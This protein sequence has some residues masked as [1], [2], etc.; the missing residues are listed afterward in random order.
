MIAAGPKKLPIVIMIDFHSDRMSKECFGALLS[1]LKSR[2]YNTLCV[3]TIP[4]DQVEILHHYTLS[5]SISE[6]ILQEVYE[7]L[8]SHQVPIVNKEQLP[9]I[10]Y[11]ELAALLFS[12]GISNYQEVADQIYCMPSARKT[13]KAITEA[14]NS[15]FMLRGVDINDREKNKTPL[16]IGIR[17]HNE[18]ILE[19]AQIRGTVIAANVIKLRK[20]K[21]HNH[22]E[23]GIIVH[24]GAGNY[25]KM[26]SYFREQGILADCLFLYPHQSTYKGQSYEVAEQQLVKVDFTGVNGHIFVVDNEI[27]VSFFA[28]GALAQLERLGVKKIASPSAMTKSFDKTKDQQPPQKPDNSGGMDFMKGAFSKPGGLFL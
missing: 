6:R 1:E 18:M 19:T 17:K 22:D 20:E 28:Q 8:R 15:G 26:V 25:P 2:G 11:V 4:V 21:E 23:G 12:S 13:L 14:V 5:M 24:A 10:G 3:Q 27:D 16:E 7:H 9:Q